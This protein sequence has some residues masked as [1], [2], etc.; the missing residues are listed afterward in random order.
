MDDDVGNPES[1]KISLS[2]LINSS[3]ICLWNFFDKSRG[4]TR[5]LLYVLCPVARFLAFKIISSFS[6]ANFVLGCGDWGDPKSLFKIV[7]GKA[8]KVGAFLQMEKASSKFLNLMK[9]ISSLSRLEMSPL[10]DGIFFSQ[11]AVWELT[12]DRSFAFLKS[13]KSEPNLEWRNSCTV[14]DP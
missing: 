14:S 4:L 11:K 13:F 3:W 8:R 1:W 9:L 7:V 10:K 6:L 12:F 5:Y 2:F